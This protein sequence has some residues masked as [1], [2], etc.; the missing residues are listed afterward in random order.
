MNCLDVSAENRPIPAQL[1]VLLRPLLITDKA[2]TANIPT[3][4]APQQART[5]SAR[6]FVLLCKLELSP[7]DQ[8]LSGPL[9][10]LTSTLS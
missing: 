6:P 8:S 7:N 5:A 9:G 1:V 10:W 4:L 2:T 3:Q